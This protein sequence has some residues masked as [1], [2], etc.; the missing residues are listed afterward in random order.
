MAGL[1]SKDFRM[2][3]GDTR[4]IAL[5]E[6]LIEG[7]KSPFTTIDGK[8]QPF[9]KITYP[10]PRSGRLVTKIAT[11]LTDSADITTV[12]RTGSVPFKNIQLS[13]QRGNQVTNMLPLD[14]IMK[15]EEFG[16]RS[17]LGDM[18]EL[19]YSAAA[20]QRF[21]NKN[22]D[23][24]FTDVTDMLKMLND[25]DTHQIIGPMKSPNLEPRIV[26]DLYWEINSP[27]INIRAIKNPRHIRNLK[28]VI[29]AAVH[30]ANSPPV[31]KAAKKV[32]ENSLYNRIDIKAIGSTA[33][34]DTRIDVYAYIDKVKIDLTTS[35]EKQ[36]RFVNKSSG[37]IDDHKYIWSSL[38]DFKIGPVLQK[39]YFTV[40]KKFGL[41]MANRIVY[42][43]LA[44]EFNRKIVSNPSDVYKSLSDGIVWFSA[45]QDKTVDMPSNLSNKE[46][47]IF[48]FHNLQVSLSLKNIHLKAVFVDSSTKPCINFSDNKTGNILFSLCMKIDDKHNY[49][50]HHI[51]KGKLIGD[52][53]RIVAA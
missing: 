17:N 48:L 13:Y 8:Q 11:D 42:K 40:L 4:I 37:S 26:D 39:N 19:I 7:P 33:Q 15:T 1:S 29:D 30:W 34:N 2:S 20:V 53:Q 44:K 10:D 24:V 36:K 27:I 35:S 43:E 22:A 28:R 25:S 31:A 49:V 41:G 45:R 12:I 38:L 23:V 9:N 5:I 3:H 14:Q 52:L 32:F 16:G 18:T 46:S 50:A 21:L 51:E 47:K 6:K